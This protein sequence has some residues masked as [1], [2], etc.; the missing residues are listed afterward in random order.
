MTNVFG[1]GIIHSPLVTKKLHEFSWSFGSAQTALD[2][3]TQNITA[4]RRVRGEV[5]VMG[6][7]NNTGFIMDATIPPRRR[8]VNVIGSI[9]ARTYWS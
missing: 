4:P 7:E 3:Y 8:G 5:V 2:F 9:I 6:M 1:F